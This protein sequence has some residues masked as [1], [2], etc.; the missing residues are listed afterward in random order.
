[1]SQLKRIIFNQSLCT[2]L[3]GVGVKRSED[4]SDHAQQI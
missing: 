2:G 4:R 1:M 3:I